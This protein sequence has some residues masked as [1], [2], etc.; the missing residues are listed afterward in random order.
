MGLGFWR[1]D[2]GGCPV[3][4]HQGVAQHPERWGELCG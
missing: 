4:E 1:V 3:V 2:L